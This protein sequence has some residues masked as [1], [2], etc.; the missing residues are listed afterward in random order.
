MRVIFGLGC[1]VVISL[2]ILS[3][4]DIFHLK[5]QN[6]E[7]LENPTRQETSFSSIIA[8][9]YS[10]QRQIIQ[11][12]W[13]VLDDSVN[14]TINSSG[15]GWVGIGF[16][17]N[18]KMTNAD[19]LVFDSTGKWSDRYTHDWNILPYL[20]LH[21]DGTLLFASKKNDR[22]IIRFT[23]QINTNDVNDLRLDQSSFLLWAIGDSP[24]AP[25]ETFSK[26][27]GHGIIG[28]SLAEPSFEVYVVAEIEPTLRNFGTA[29]IHGIFMTIS[30]ISCEVVAI[31]IIRYMRQA[32]FRRF[33]KVAITY[34]IFYSICGLFL[35]FVGLWCGMDAVKSYNGPHFYSPH[36]ILGLSIIIAT[37]LNGFIGIIAQRGKYFNILHRW[38]GLITTV[39]ALANISLG[40]EQLGVRTS[41]WVF[42]F[43]FLTALIILVLF[44]E[45][46]QR[47]EKENQQTSNDSSDDS[48][49]LSPESQARTKILT[50]FAIIISFL[51]T[52]AIGLAIGL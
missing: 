35:L 41:A 45:L 34:H 33:G 38:L 25:D 49:I 37:I 17:T 27:I 16:N 52:I 19:I 21:Q 32:E 2:F 20:D 11:I 12:S 44:L 39:F 5:I 18:A 43:L 48:F 24:I 23:R 47:K 26:H 1:I 42:Y 6:D 10:S 13:V 8:G 7:I 50:S 14:F 29:Q 51:S 31:L 9:S 4:Y 22:T 30:W 36:E 28:V 40:M 15:F 46:E 3:C